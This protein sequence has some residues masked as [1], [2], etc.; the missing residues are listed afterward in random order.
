MNNINYDIE[1]LSDMSDTSAKCSTNTCRQMRLSQ[2]KTD[3]LDASSVYCPVALT[4][5]NNSAVC[6]FRLDNGKDWIKP[7]VFSGWVSGSE[8]CPGA[9]DKDAAQKIDSHHTSDV[10]SEHITVTQTSHSLHTNTH[11]LNVRADESESLSLLAMKKKKKKKQ[12]VAER[13]GF[14]KF[15]LNT[16]FLH[17]FQMFVCPLVN[18]LMGTDL[19]VFMEIFGYEWGCTINQNII[20][21][22]KGQVQ[23]PNRRSCNF[24]IKLKCVTK[25]PYNEVV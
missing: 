10:L 20:E 6:Y 23:Y 4:N 8:L 19:N 17:F 22:T 3:M 24:M 9:A 11:S 25:Q 13:L 5:L 2:K 16:Q 18:W 21:F 14:N 1:P 15:A 12:S 7:K